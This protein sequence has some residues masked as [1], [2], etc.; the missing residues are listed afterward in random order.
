VPLQERWFFL[1]FHPKFVAPG[2]TPDAELQG[3]IFLSMMS[4]ALQAAFKDNARG[5]NRAD[6]IIFSCGTSF[7]QQ[8]QHGRLVIL[9]LHYIPV[10]RGT[11]N[12]PR[13][14]NPCSDIGSAARVYLFPA[15]PVGQG[16]LRF[17][18]HGRSRPVNLGYNQTVNVQDVNMR[19]SDVNDSR[20]PSDVIC[21]WEGRVSILVGLQDSSGNL[22][23][24]NLSLRGSR[25]A[26][27]TR[28]FGNYSIRL[29]EVQPYPVST[30][31]ALKSYYVATF[32]VDFSQHQVARR[33][34]KG[35]CS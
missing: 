23:Q 11:G 16:C 19:F 13:V 12:A 5:H 1:F 18:Y 8:H 10:C 27:S 34:C 31:Q 9:H 6:S 17:R 21:I 15:G 3:S 35:T 14:W 29:V 20:C 22:Y 25:E 4:F 2:L 26:P 33:P 24:L 28:S 7:C 32:V 30:E